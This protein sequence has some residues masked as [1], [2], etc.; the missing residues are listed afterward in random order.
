MPA[1]IGFTTLL[2]KNLTNKAKN[3]RIFITDI[4][5]VKILIH[6]FYDAL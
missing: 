5:T 2:F 4:H 6:L 1:F 3:L